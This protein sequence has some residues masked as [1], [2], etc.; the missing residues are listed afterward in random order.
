M[1]NRRGRGGGGR[2]SGRGGAKPASFAPFSGIGNVL[3]GSSSGSSTPPYLPA[4]PRAATSRPY[5]SGRSGELAVRGQN[6]VGFDYANLQAKPRGTTSHQQQ[7]AAGPSSR[8]QSPRPSDAAPLGRSP[9]AKGRYVK[10]PAYPAFVTSRGNNGRNGRPSEETGESKYLAGMGGRGGY[11]SRGGGRKSAFRSGDPAE[12][13]S[14]FAPVEFIKASGEWKDGQWTGKEPV[15]DKPSDTAQAPDGSQLRRDAINARPVHAGL[16]FSKP[17]GPIATEEYSSASAQESSS[18]L[19]ASDEETAEDQLAALMQ[20]FPGSRQLE[21]GEESEVLNSLLQHETSFAAPP[22]LPSSSSSSRESEGPITSGLEVTSGPG[23]ADMEGVETAAMGDDDS[24]AAPA[25]PTATIKPTS[26][27]IRQEQ[28]TVSSSRSKISSDSEDD[29]EIILIPQSSGRAPISIANLAAESD[30]EEERQLDAIIAASRPLGEQAMQEPAAPISQDPFVIDFT[31]DDAFNLEQKAAAPAVATSSF[32]LGEPS[33]SS[34]DVVADSSTDADLTTASEAAD[35]SVSHANIIVDSSEDEFVALPG[36]QSRPQPSG[37]GRKARIAAKKARRKARKA[38]AAAQDEDDAGGDGLRRVPAAIPREGDS[39]L[40]WGSD[41]P[42]QPRYQKNNGINPDD[43]RLRELSLS[44]QADAPR[45]RADE[46]RMIQEALIMS[47]QGSRPSATGVQFSSISVKAKKGGRQTRR[48][49]EQEAVLADYL[50]NVLRQEQVEVEEERMAVVAGSG[51][52]EDEDDDRLDRPTDMDAMLQFMRGMDPQQ[53]GRQLTLGDI[54]DEL[55][56]QEEDEWMTESGEDDDDSDGDFDAAAPTTADPAQTRGADIKVFKPVS[57][58]N[59]DHEMEAAMNAAEQAEIGE[60]E[61]SDD[62]DDDD[63]EEESYTDEDE[64]TYDEDADSEQ[65][66]DEDED[67][68]D[69]VFSKNFSWAAEDEAFINKIERFAQANH[70][71]LTG[72]DRKARNR[73]YKAIETGDFDGPDFDDDVA[74]GIAPAKK[75]KGP[76]KT[77]K[78]GDIW[79][80]SLQ[81]QWEKDRATKADHKRKRAEERRL[82]AMDPYPNTHQKKGTKKMAKKAARAA[83]RATRTDEDND[84]WDQEH[85]STMIKAKNGGTPL[86]QRSA[87]NLVQLDNQIHDFL[88][89]DGHGTMALPPM[90][91]RSRAQVHMLADAYSLKSKSRGAG[92]SRFITLI[93]VQRSG[94]NVD[95]RKVKSILYGRGDESFGIRGPRGLKAKG[96]TSGGSKTGGSAPANIDGSAVGSGADKIGADNIGHRLLTMMGWAEGS[97]VGANQDGMSEPVGA[98]IKNSKGGLGF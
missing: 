1:S 31:G 86:M 41:G 53:G 26:P 46:E 38:G 82:A 39:D 50:E 18:S 11:S 55:Q 81:K 47:Q 70:D 52:D 84:A 44:A 32:V 57:S 37:T 15:A 54:H 9:F 16:G 95:T 94:K 29:D 67:D 35:A 36:H 28:P 68:D 63:D 21:A 62:D 48:Q 22:H 91:K 7:E 4:D 56:M 80:D 97:G 3:G 24:L 65:D 59:E 27:S 69:N 79:A 5:H 83:R 77:W 8:T 30:S 78:D 10:E 72:S 76:K 43:F 34:S 13:A 64:D 66:E 87:N 92:R 60:S 51:G 14:M 71:V 17:V 20:A 23:S 6:A 40:D 2:G 88:D 33:S 73:L 45:T 25:S 12:R 90:D 42:P 96:G 19:P 49:Q 61:G 75:G 93:K 58:R 85:G 98:T 74:M 89:D